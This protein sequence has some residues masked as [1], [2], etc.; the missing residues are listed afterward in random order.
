MNVK[1][2]A[3]QRTCPGERYAISA[4]IC[5]TRQRNQYPKCLLCS[6]RSPELAG[7]AATDPKVPA[8]IFRSAAVLGHVPQ[9]INEYVMRKVGLAAAQLLRSETPTGSRMAVACDLRD[10]SRGFTRIFSEG[11]NRGGMHTVNIGPLPPEV[12][13]FALG[14][15]GYAGAAFIGGGNYPDAVNGVRL[16]RGDASMLGAGTGLEKV[17]LIARRLRTGCARLPG[18]TST[19]NP[20]G[21]Y[22]AHVLKLAPK[23]SP[24]KVVADV[25]HGVAGRVIGHLFGG[26]PVEL[27]MAHAEEDAHNQFLGRRFPSQSLVASMRA[28]VQDARADLGAAIDFDGES[29][30]FFDEA[31]AMLGHDVAAGVIAGEL[32]ARSPGEIVTYDLRA[33]AALGASVSRAGGRPLPG[34]TAP[35]A[36]GQHFRRSDA[37]YGAD[38]TGL[39]YFKGYF[40][41]PSPIVALLLFCCRLSREQKRV[42]QLA[43]DLTRFSHSGE[44][45]IPLASAEA[46]SGILARVSE[47]FKNADRDETDGLTVR[48]QDWWFNLRQPG[49][50]PE[51]RLNVEGRTPRD[52]KRGR[53]M[54]DRIIQKAIAG[55]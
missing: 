31:G 46:G 8:S 51:L 15:D 50:V 49:E 33:T 19:A 35:L 38:L 47:E 24:L 48:L 42:T 36:F 28:Q 39:H 17:G 7:S 21:D 2:P 5:R 52:Q 13:A 14:T 3:P 6:H 12:L 29:V 54:L 53:Q 23:L 30:A 45:V 18:E 32:L 55:G 16:W 10:S 34:P 25:G 37:L 9:E 20:L 43:A 22:M 27:T 4:A 1:G 40:R 26:L 44:I 41:F 11:V